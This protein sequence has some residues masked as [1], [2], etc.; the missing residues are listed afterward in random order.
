MS[1]LLYFFKNDASYDAT[2][3]TIQSAISTMPNLDT[4]Y[5]DSDTEQE[6]V[7]YFSIETTPAVVVLDDDKNEV[8]RLVDTNITTQNLT[9]LYNQIPQY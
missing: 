1:K 7:S 5:I 3:E 4:V 9:D 6:Q 8:G 2:T